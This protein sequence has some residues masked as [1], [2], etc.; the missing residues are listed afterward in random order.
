MTIY[1]LGLLLELL[2]VNI[3]RPNDGGEY[4]DEST[5]CGHEGAELV[6]V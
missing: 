3:P 2:D 4:S 5:E 6:L 1:K